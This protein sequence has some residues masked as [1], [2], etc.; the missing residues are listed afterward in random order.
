M[1]NKIIFLIVT[2]L[3]LCF[4]LQRT[5]WLADIKGCNVTLLL[6]LSNNYTNA[7]LEL[8]MVKEELMGNSKLSLEQTQLGDISSPTGFSQTLTLSKPTPSK[9]ITHFR[10]QGKHHRYKLIEEITLDKFRIISETGRNDYKVVY[11]IPTV[12]RPNNQIYLTQTLNSLLSDPTSIQQLNVLLIV[13]VADI[14]TDRCQQVADLARLDHEQSFRTGNIEVVC[15]QPT[16]Y[17]SL[18]D[19]P[20]TLGDPEDRVKWRSKQNLDFAFLMWYASQKGDYYVQ[21]EDDIIA[22]GDYA[23]HIDHHVD[24]VED[25]VWFLIH[26]SSLGFI[27]KLMR[28]NDLV[29]FVSYLLLFYSNQPCDWLLEDYGRT[30]VCHLGLINQEC[31]ALVD[32]IFTRY[33]ISLFQHMGTLSSLEGKTQ[34]AKD[35]LFKESTMMPFKRPIHTNPPAKIYSTFSI[36]GYHTANRLYEGKGYFWSDIIHKGD[37]IVAEFLQPQLLSGVLIRSGS[38]EIPLDIL[39]YGVVELKTQGNND[40]EYWCE[41]KRGEASCSSLTTRLVSGIRVLATETQNHWLVITHFECVL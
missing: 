36:H 10:P 32:N 40:Y 22:V 2:L 16:L 39:E 14:D 4:L 7:Q 30:L 12:A 15:P 6:E 18:E 20:I 28:S 35:A 9:R 29:S 21:L 26:F 17:P 38:I 3:L 19:L 24:K 34:P 33:S 13:F 27:G 11:G 31:D 23:E 8:E 25:G 5:I 41:F 37:S 1:R